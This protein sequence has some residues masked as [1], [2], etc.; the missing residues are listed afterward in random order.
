VNRENEDIR[1]KIERCRRIASYMTDDELRHSLEEL[2]Q[3]YESRLGSGAGFM[4]RDSDRARPN[5][6]RPRRDPPR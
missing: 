2:A 5:G 4:L 3:E 1:I 6:I